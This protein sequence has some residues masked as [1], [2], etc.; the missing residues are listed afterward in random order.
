MLL[1]LK[2]VVPPEEN[3]KGKAAL[4]ELFNDLKNQN[5]P[6]IVERI[7]FDIDSI[8]KIVR[9]D[10]RQKTTTGVR[11]VEKTLSSVVWTK[12]W[13]YRTVLLKGKKLF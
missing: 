10:G 13:I 9:F 6:V 12:Y 11:E 7:V 1:L 8:V 5:T 3:D 2:K 4:T